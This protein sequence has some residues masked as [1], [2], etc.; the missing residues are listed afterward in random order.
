MALAAPSGE[1]QRERATGGAGGGS[2]GGAK[3]I[4]EIDLSNAK[5]VNSARVNQAKSRLNSAFTH[6]T[7][8]KK[9]EAVLELARALMI[10]PGLVDD[11]GAQG[12][13][14]SLSGMGGKAA[15]QEVLRMANAVPPKTTA[16]SHDRE[17]WDMILS[18]VILLIVIALFSIVFFYGSY[19][20]QAYVEALVYN[21]PL[22]NI[23]SL[24]VV[25]PLNMVL[26]WVLRLGAL[27][28]GSTFFQF[29]IVYAVATLMMGGTG[30][31]IRHL[32]VSMNVAVI[33]YI[34]I[35]IGFAILIGAV[36]GY[37]PTSLA[38]VG[39]LMLVG[40]GLGTFILQAFL[41]GRVHEFGA[42]KGAYSVILGSIGAGIIAGLLGMFRPQE[43]RF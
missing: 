35:M 19:V 2:G 41:L 21:Q 26:P 43:I 4:P 17:F 22:P 1:G 5:A 36:T 8:G 29:T 37:V 23:R 7:Q 33:G 34:S 15:F 40:S 24:F 39:L 31:M 25:F 10:N 11:P 14:T 13:A 18:G 38:N 12:L 16:P 6:M 20:I 32:R 42:I 27:T 3:A 28:L 30:S 9:D